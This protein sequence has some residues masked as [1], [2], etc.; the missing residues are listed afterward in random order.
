MKT[1]VPTFV[2]DM[3]MTPK[4]GSNNTDVKNVVLIPTLVKHVAQESR[5]CSISRPRNI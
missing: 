2:L 1:D 4:N 5:S 3:M